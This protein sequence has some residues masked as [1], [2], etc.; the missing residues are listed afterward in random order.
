VF[1]S[2][3]LS[4]R[5]EL[6]QILAGIRYPT[7]GFCSLLGVDSKRIL[8]GMTFGM[9]DEARDSIHGTCVFNARQHSRYLCVRFATAFTVLVCSIRDGIHGTCVFDSR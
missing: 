3:S 4:G 8:R 1:G 9:R 2:E 7:D 5:S 6:L